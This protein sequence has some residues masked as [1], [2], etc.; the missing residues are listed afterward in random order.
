M[1]SLTTQTTSVLLFVLVRF[2]RLL[3][4][5]SVE[6]VSNQ[7]DFNRVKGYHHIYS[8]ATDESEDEEISSWAKTAI[9]YSLTFIDSLLSLAY[10]TS[11]L[12]GLLKPKDGWKQVNAGNE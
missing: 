8:N 3:T 7:W 5:V 12:S 9:K 2:A 10:N 11:Q 4:A 1:P 6:E